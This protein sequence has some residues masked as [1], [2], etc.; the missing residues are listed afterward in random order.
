MA[1]GGLVIQPPFFMGKTMSAKSTNR[2]MKV[3]TADA[4]VKEAPAPKAPSF[5]TFRSASPETHE[6][7]I[8]GIRAIRGP[9]MRLTFTVPA[10]KADRFAK[11]HHVTTGRVVRR[12]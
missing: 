9:D 2:T 12:G 7:T 4:P 1:E 6:I 11:H 5:V 3:K 10:D 8:M